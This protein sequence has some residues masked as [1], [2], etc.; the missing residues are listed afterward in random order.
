MEENTQTYSYYSFW[1]N[2]FNFTGRTKRKEFWITF[3]INFL[4]FATIPLMILPIMGSTM[5]GVI[6]LVVIILIPC[7]SILTRRLRDTGAGW[8]WVFLVLILF[9][10]FIPLIVLCCLP[11]KKTQKNITNSFIQ[12][13][14]YN[15]N[16]A[17]SGKGADDISENE[18]LELVETLTSDNQ[19]QQNKKTRIITYD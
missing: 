7:L 14:D 5:N 10:S 1:R 19:I 15:D 17:V 6:F 9:I 13:A 8:G 18:Q 3:L 12:D 16:L 11:S 2:Y 4:L